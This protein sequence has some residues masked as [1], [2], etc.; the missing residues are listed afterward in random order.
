MAPG[1]FTHS[2][3]GGGDE[4]PCLCAALTI[5]G[6]SSKMMGEKV[7]FVVT[8]TFAQVVVGVTKG[9]MPF[10]E[11]GVSA[12]FTELYTYQWYVN[13][14]NLGG[15]GHVFPQVWVQYGKS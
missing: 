7:D 10:D 12:G 15:C 11:S 9:V 8:E 1:T 14:A 6:L 4:P 3:R 2:L 13:K 5:L